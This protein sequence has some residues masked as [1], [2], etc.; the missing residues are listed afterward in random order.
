ME[1]V[2]KTRESEKIDAMLE[3][4]R[5]GLSIFFYMMRILEFGWQ[6][7]ARTICRVDWACLS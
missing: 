4:G 3:I 7:S 1:T 2:A 5:Y 6:S